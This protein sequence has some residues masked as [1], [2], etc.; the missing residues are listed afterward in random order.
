[1][2]WE[3]TAPDL[4]GIGVHDVLSLQVHHEQRVTEVQ[5]RLCFAN[6]DAAGLD[7]DTQAFAIPER[8]RGTATGRETS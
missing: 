6:S 8:V 7:V 5:H 1:M 4:S 2:R 3:S